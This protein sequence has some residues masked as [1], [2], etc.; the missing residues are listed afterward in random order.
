MESD[1]ELMLEDATSIREAMR[2]MV[3]Y[4]S[5]ALENLDRRIDE[6]ILDGRTEAKELRGALEHVQHPTLGPDSQL[7]PDYARD[8]RM[9]AP[10]TRST[11]P[12][13]SAYERATTLSRR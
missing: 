7:R 6:E 5:D 2:R 12:Q 8:K 11:I 3:Q 4:L 9:A 1:R 10:K 13:N